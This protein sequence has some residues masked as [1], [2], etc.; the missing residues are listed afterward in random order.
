LEVVGVLLVICT[1][2]FSVC[3][4]IVL[5]DKGLE[6]LLPW[7]DQI[8]FIGWVCATTAG[9]SILL[10]VLV[11]IIIATANRMAV[12]PANRFPMLKQYIC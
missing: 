3:L 11:A 7:E 4:N 1:T 6:E 2:A 12:A 5:R 9:L 8:E 10:N